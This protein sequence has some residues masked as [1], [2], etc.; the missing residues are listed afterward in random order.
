[1]KRTW[2][3]IGLALAGCGF[4]VLAQKQEPV[5][6]G[7]GTPVANSNTGDATDP[8]ASNPNPTPPKM[9]QVQV[10]LIEL[11]HEALTKLLFLA[12]PRSTDATALRKHL[13]EMVSKNDAKVLETQIL[14]AKS[15]QR[16]TTESIHET[17][18]PAE[19]TDSMFEK[20]LKGPFPFAICDPVAFET[21][22]VGNTLEIEPTVGE[23][24]RTI[25][26]RFNPELNWKTGDTVWHE[27]KDS[28]GNPF[29]KTVPNFYVIRLNTA[30][31]CIAGQYNFAAA[32][33]PKDDKGNTDLTRKV[34]VFVKCDVLAVK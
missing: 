2:L 34:M 25:D 5:P 10:E 22:N 11:S 30:L 13:Q 24:N 27:G 21:R 8:F 23:D 3:I 33:S 16:A 32:I 18:Y 20:K 1:M 14:I 4:L 17:I 12:A 9:I 15:G 7:T 6:T 31:T 19:Y 29:K 28:L 26:L